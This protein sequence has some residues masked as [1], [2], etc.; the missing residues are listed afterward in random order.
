[1]RTFWLTA[2]LLTAVACSSGP[3]IP[4]QGCPAC[5]LGDAGKPDA[6][7]KAPDAGRV[8]AGPPDAGLPDAG[9]PDSGVPDAG[10]PDSG[11]DA[12]ATDAG[13]PLTGTVCPGG[14]DGGN[15]IFS[16]QVSDLCADQSQ[17]TIIPL[18]GVQVATLSPYSATLTDANG[19][20]ALCIPPNN[21]VTIV[22]SLTGYVTTYIAEYNFNST[23]GSLPS[24]AGEMQLTCSSALQA[25]AEEDPNVNLNEAAIY[26]A[27]V[28]AL[29]YTPPCDSDDA[30]FTGWTFQ[31]TLPDGGAGPGGPWP[32]GYFD[33]SGDL[34]LVSSSF[35]NGRVLMYNVDPSVSYASVTATNASLGSQCA[36]L[37]TVIGFTGRVYV[38]PGAFSFF[39]WAVP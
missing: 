14:V 27:V 12:G 28:A 37:D 33:D 21:P 39:P 24:I 4:V 31:A 19:N 23:I 17:H 30:G 22:F 6:G 13:L 1:M 11:P 29:P 5:K 36:A 25:Y 7:E 32:T 10:V 26:S 16:G 9:P 34:Q 2:L 35:A 15:E 38:A 8:D 3:N 20:Y 18:Q